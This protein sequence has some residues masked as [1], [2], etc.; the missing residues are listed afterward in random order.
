MLPVRLAYGT[1]FGVAGLLCLVALPRTRVL[2]DVDTRRGFAALLALCGLWAWTTAAQLLVDMV[3][4][5]T[6]LYTV[7]LSFGFATIFAWLYFC[8]AFAGRRF[9]REP[10]L[11][12]LALGIYLLVAGLKFTNPIHGRYFVV[13]TDPTPF[14]HLVV[15]RLPLDLT[16]T[17]FAYVLSAAGFYLLFRTLRRS[18][19]RTQS[20]WVL[21]LAAG[22]PAVPSMAA[23]VPGVGLL[24]LNYEPIGVAVFGLGVLYFV[25]EKFVAVPRFGRER[26]LDE[27]DDAVLVLDGDDRVLEYNAAALD[28]FP[29]IRGATGRPLDE[30][31]PEIA[32]APDDGD[33]L[34]VRRDGE[35][36]YLVCRESELTV[37]TTDIGTVFALT[38]V[39]RL[40]RGRR[41]LRRQNEQLDD[42]AAAVDHE[43]RNTVS[44]VEG[45][46]ALARA[47]TEDP[48]ADEAMAVVE[49]TAARMTSIVG[50]LTTL[51]RYGQTL[52]ETV[53]CRLEAVTRVAW[54][55]TDTD[56]MSLTV[57]GDATVQAD[58]DRLAELFEAVFEFA[59]V[60]GAGRV[61]VGYDGDALSIAGDGGRIPPDQHVAA[62]DYNAA[63]PSAEA[64]MLLPNAQ[65]LATVHGW[66]A[67][68]DPE[69]D[70]GVRLHI[71][72][73]DGETV[74]G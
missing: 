29:A 54:K 11:Q 48:A 40:E 19:Y 8:S 5:K 70:A 61:T 66:Q 35:E 53:P 36:R 26:L 73:V 38:D 62:M 68:L 10:V 32:A 13:T 57:D 3:A 17:T 15:Q 64:R 28:T 1:T 27:I 50:D 55:R 22:L 47:E 43:L 37:G 67:D 6:A 46:T 58:P 31:A 42:F 63:V 52:D 18:E 41:E 45:Y 49:R 14:P 69:Y 23:A 24:D 33:V 12:A 72:G 39:T 71:T 2:S 7:G 65:T 25:E 30:V 56:E 20:L 74:A 51:A 9:H 59:T 34:T 16:I 44:L 21:V 4:L 60:N